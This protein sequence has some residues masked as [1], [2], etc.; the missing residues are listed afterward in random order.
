[1]KRIFVALAAIVVLVL[2]GAGAR[3]VHAAAA[4]DLRNM[5]TRK[6]DY[7]ALRYPGYI[8]ARVLA[9]STAESITVPTNATFVVFSANCDFYV[10]YDADTAVVPS[11][12]VDDGTSNELNPT[13]RYVGGLT[14]LSVI[15]AT[16]CI[17]TA[18]FY[19]T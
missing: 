9:A 14:T 19:R 17:L 15:S 2:L 5:E 3:E 8:Q 7:G 16:A 18:S 10:S 1:M 11:A 6:F 12:D 4:A 13:V